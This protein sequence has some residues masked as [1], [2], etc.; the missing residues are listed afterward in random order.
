MPTP[1]RIIRSAW[2]WV[3]RCL[4]QEVSEKLLSPLRAA[5]F[6]VS[7]FG[8]RCVYWGGGCSLQHFVAQ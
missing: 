2:P 3:A 7:C 1:R 4:V 8:V 6:I 5:A